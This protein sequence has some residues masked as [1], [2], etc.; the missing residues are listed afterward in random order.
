LSIGEER[1]NKKGE[2]KTT[3]PTVLPEG[4]I[5]HFSQAI[6]DF[7]ALKALP[8][9]GEEI[10]LGREK[11][12]A[13]LHPI[14]NERVDSRL[15]AFNLK[16]EVL[17]GRGFF[18]FEHPKEEKKRG[19]GGR[20]GRI[21]HTCFRGEGRFRSP[22]L[23]YTRLIRRVEKG[24]AFGAPGGSG[25]CRQRRKGGTVAHKLKKKPHLTLAY[26]KRR[27]LK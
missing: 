15:R 6:E 22:Q 5:N 23:K 8:G 19:S 24:L 21:D 11:G 25:G 3:S 20:E 14:P 18:S 26:E 4:K 13:C 16:Y 9:G 27:L 2:K 7:R 17:G 1:G 12:G 10:E